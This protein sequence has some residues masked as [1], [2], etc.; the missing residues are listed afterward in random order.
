[1][2]PALWGCNKAAKF[3]DQS[4][5]VASAPLGALSL[6]QNASKDW[7]RNE[8]T[9]LAAAYTYSS[10]IDLSSDRGDSFDHA[11]LVKVCPLA[12]KDFRRK[13]PGLAGR[14]AFCLPS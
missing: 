12:D 8:K 9:K 11:L 5:I 13:P 7:S 14:A 2:P 4:M 10:R 3:A 6:C 1:M